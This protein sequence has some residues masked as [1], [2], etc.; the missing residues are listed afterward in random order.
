MKKYYFFSGYVDVFINA[1]IGLLF[2]WECVALENQAEA[3]FQIILHLAAWA[4][5][6]YLWL[7]FTNRGRLILSVFAIPFKIILS[8]VFLFSSVGV[9]TSIFRKDMELSERVS[10]GVISGLFF[11]FAKRTV[12]NSE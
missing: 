2:L 1:V 11:F 12:K 5:F 3:A 4:V 8:Y 6:S 10:K 7:I 9:I